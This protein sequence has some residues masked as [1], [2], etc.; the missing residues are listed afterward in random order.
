MHVL[1]TMFVIWHYLTLSLSELFNE[2]AFIAM[3]V[4]ILCQVTYMI[5][6]P[7]IQNCFG[8]RNQK[9]VGT[10]IQLQEMYMQAHAFFSMLKLDF[11]TGILLVLLTSFFLF[12]KPDQRF[13]MYANICAMAV[14]LIWA[15]VGY[16]AVR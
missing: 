16:F 11:F 3:V 10:D 7:E 9:R 5:C 8:W 1:I 12:R 2:W 6:V 15:L 14:S 4:V 13:E